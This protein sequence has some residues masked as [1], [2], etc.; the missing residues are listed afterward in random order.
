MDADE[1]SELLPLLQAQAVQAPWDAGVRADLGRA[2]AALGD[3][4]GALRA[5]HT[6]LSL[7]PS[8]VAAGEALWTLLDGN[9]DATAAA[10]AAL[11]ADATATWA[12]LRLATQH[13]AAG[14]HSEAIPL[15]QSLLRAE[16]QHVAAWCSLGRCFDAVGKQAAARRALGRA[17]ELSPASSD[18]GA[19]LCALLDAAGE[20]AAADAAATAALQ[21]APAAHWA[22]A[23]A[24]AAF[25]SAGRHADALPA[26]QSL[27][28]ADAEDAG[29]WEA[30]G[31]CYLALGRPSAAAKAFSRVLALAA[32]PAERPYATV[33][34]ASLALALGGAAAA[35]ASAVAACS[36]TAGHPAALTAA[37]AAAL[38]SAR[39]AFRG[40]AHARAAAALERAATAAAAAAAASGTLCSAWKALGDALVAHRDV[41]PQR[42]QLPA[43]PRAAGVCAY[44]ARVTACLRGS[45]AFSH[46]VHLAPWLGTAW[47]DV[48][49]ARC[50]AAHALRASRR[51][52]AARAQCDALHEAATRAAR[53]GLRCEPACA[54]LWSTLA[55]A[56]LQHVAAESALCRALVLDPHVPGAAAALGR[57]YLLA[58][59]DAEV[60]LVR[61]AALLEAARASDAADAGA[62]VS[63]ALMFAAQRNE[64]QAMGGLRRAV[65][66]GGSP[67][68]DALLAAALS[69]VASSQ[70]E[71]HGAA[72][73]AIAALPLQAGARAALACVY[74]ARGLHTEAAAVYA[75]AADLADDA[76][77]ADKLRAAAAAAS[78]AADAQAC[79]VRKLNATRTALGADLEQTMK[80]AAAMDAACSAAL[81]SHGVGAALLQA[82]LARSAPAARDA[83][84]SL[85]AAND[86]AVLLQRRCAHA[87][88][89]LPSHCRMV[90]SGEP[91]CG[92]VLSGEPASAG[93]AWSQF[94]HLHASLLAT[95]RHG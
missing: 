40:G 87:L 83:C 55:A 15:L 5:L 32:D 59:A 31:A 18:A 43:E 4:A 54:A 74:H 65:A 73:R 51:D 27:C 36:A 17:V 42:A 91:H 81:V 95:E 90:A 6:A 29:A 92:M 44:A 80:S 58:D 20:S 21:R 3:H 8:N 47:G 86:A 60:A 34:L 88:P 63:T 53:A 82:T 48:A 35:E 66:A 84:A 50:A 85:L 11:A 62:W 38:L 57:L 16:P 94:A 69:G 7:E 14:C 78:A 33:A 79:A 12:A 77:A 61:A 52:D 39:E 45:A 25:T 93:S 56:A 1:A 10:S 64:D 72:S 26:L 22:A 2:R 13:E 28:R 37:A 49:S 71:A 67:E 19:A 23:R 76:D 70:H 30:L 24:A 75:H 89:V 9:A 41:T 46:A 68:A